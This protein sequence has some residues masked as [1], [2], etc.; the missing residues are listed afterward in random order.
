MI[1]EPI[2][3]FPQT[4]TPSQEEPS[5]EWPHVLRIT[6]TKR[7]KVCCYRVI[8]NVEL[9]VKSVGITAAIAPQHSS[10]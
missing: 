9:D 10:R 3:P 8:T 2:V 7:E 1:D 4:I 5:I 6:S